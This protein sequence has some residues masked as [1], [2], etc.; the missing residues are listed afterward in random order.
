[1]DPS[2]GTLKAVIVDVDGTLYDLAPVRRWMRWRLA[3]FALSHP[4]R[5]WKTIRALSA[6]RRAQE[7]LRGAGAKTSIQTAMA[8]ERSGCSQDFV[9]GCVA[10]WMEEEPLSAVAKARYKGVAEFFEWADQRD[11]KIAVVSDY[12]PRKKLRVLGVERYIQVSVWAQESEV[13]AFKPDPR[14]LTVAAQRLGIAPA[15]AIYIG[16][17]LDVDGAAARAAGM[18]CVLLSPQRRGQLVLEAESWYEIGD[19]LNKLIGSS[20]G[21]QAPTLPVGPFP[22]GQEVSLRP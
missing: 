15:E 4:R 7:R 21:I 22:V 2:G 11:L 10:R 17:R 9:E 16:D 1:M 14:G 12:D 5:G 3:S 18:P 13:G 8:S 6:F 19:L 20:G